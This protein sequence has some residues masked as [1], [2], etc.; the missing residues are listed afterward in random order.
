MS[1]LYALHDITVDGGGQ[2]LFAALAAAIPELGRRQARQAILAGLVQSRG[3]VLREPNFPVATRTLLRVDL[4]QGVRAVRKAQDAGSAGGSIDKPFTILHED[5]H[6]LVVDKAA[7]VLSAPTPE[8]DHGYVAEHL[9]TLWR[10]RGRTTPFIGQIHR[11]DQE[12]S[13]CLCFAMARASQRV[14]AAQFAGDA[15]GRTYRCLV[16]GSP[17]ADSGTESNRLGR[18]DDGRRTVVEDDE[19]GRDAVTHWK[20]MQRYG[21]CSELEVRLETGRTHQI[22]V[23]LAAIG[24]PVLGDRLYGRRI[25]SSAPRVPRLMLHAWKLEL[26]H[27]R[28]GERL[29]VTAPMPPVFAEVLAAIPPSPYARKTAPVVK[30]GAPTKPTSNAKAAPAPATPAKKTERSAKLPAK[31]PAKPAAHSNQVTIRKSPRPDQPPR[32]RKPR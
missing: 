5:A 17:R 8:Q 11:L 31:A 13:G 27:P 24:H 3:K 2:P 6:V 1:E 14:L 18:G 9:R 28:S 4:R 10:A 16:A 12:T 30:P 7:G 32:A 20:V 15:A 29:S 22:R 19:P 25:P 21:T 26:D 23:H